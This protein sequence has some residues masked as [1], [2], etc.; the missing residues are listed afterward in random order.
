MSNFDPTAMP[1]FAEDAPSVSSLLF[2][3][4]DVLRTAQGLN[5]TRLEVLE[6]GGYDSIKRHVVHDYP[7][8]FVPVDTDRVI[9]KPEGEDRMVDGILRLILKFPRGGNLPIVHPNDVFV[10]TVDVDENRRRFLANLRGL[11]EYGS[12]LDLVPVVPGE[13]NDNDMYE[14]ESPESNQ[15]DEVQFLLDLTKV[16]IPTVQTGRELER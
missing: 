10:E 4:R 11:N 9:L 5:D 3:F 8:E 1:D 7:N 2:R 12:I 6:E 16:Y 14:V 15:A 13:L